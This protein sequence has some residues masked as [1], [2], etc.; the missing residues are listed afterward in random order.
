MAFL[1]R[2]QKKYMGRIA[3]SHRSY[4]R[5]KISGNFLVRAKLKVTLTAAERA[6]ATEQC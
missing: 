6:A 3:L 5:K 2:C 4:V 1:A